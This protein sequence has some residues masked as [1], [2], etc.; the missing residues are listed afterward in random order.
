MLCGIPSLSPSQA[1]LQL[2]I[3]RNSD[4]IRRTSSLGVSTVNASFKDMIP[5]GC[6]GSPIVV[7]EAI[8]LKWH[9]LKMW[10]PGARPV[11]GYE[12]E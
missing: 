11:G 1:G 7:P 6:S 8:A 12:L 4:R 3:K 2:K 10:P 9:F 5:V